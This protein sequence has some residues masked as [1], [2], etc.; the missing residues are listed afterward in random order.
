M[1][2]SLKRKA[3]HLADRKKVN[4]ALRSDMKVKGASQKFYNSSTE[5]H[6]IVKHHRMNFKGQ[7]LC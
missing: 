7:S 4:Q 5:M 6:R 3:R 2:K 1:L